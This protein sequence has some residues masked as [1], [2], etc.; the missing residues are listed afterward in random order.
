VV[1]LTAFDDD[2]AESAVDRV[3]IAIIEAAI[4]RAGCRALAGEQANT[5]TA[6]G[7]TLSLALSSVG[8][9]AI[10]VSLDGQFPGTAADPSQAI[11]VALPP[12]PDDYPVEGALVPTT[13]ITVRFSAG[14]AGAAGST[15]LD[16]VLFVRRAPRGFFVSAN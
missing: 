12:A 5:I 10:E 3:P 9:T 2:G 6:S 8:A 1:A 15:H 13:T 14:A 4:D 16:R 7:E 11:E